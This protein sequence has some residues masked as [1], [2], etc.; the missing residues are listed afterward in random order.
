[1]ISFFVLL[2]FVVC[3]RA[4]CFLTH[5]ASESEA[6]HGRPERSVVFH[7]PKGYKE[8]ETSRVGVCVFV[9]LLFTQLG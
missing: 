4:S 9:F 6:I 7:L 2:C 5:R 3:S 1:M 8:R